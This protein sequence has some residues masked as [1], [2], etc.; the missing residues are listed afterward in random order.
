MTILSRRSTLGLGLLV[1][2]GLP[3]RGQGAGPVRIRGT[4]VRLEG[5][6][7]AV[8]T[9]ADESVIVNLAEN[10]TVSALRRVALADLTPGT[11]VGV[12]AEPGA[13]GELRATAITVLPPGIRIT[14]LQSA[15]DTAPNAS[16]NN[17]A[18]EA[19][20][21]SSAG[22]DLTLSILGRRVLVRVPADTPLLMPIP[23]ARTDLVAGATVFINA[24]RGGDGRISANRV[25]VS[26][27]GVV[28]VI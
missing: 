28:P 27:D 23:A 17:G 10:T 19:A 11:S 14:E 12:V 25:T 3:A 4:I 7:L 20:V 5:A 24:T 13:D 22:R 9:R 21:D 8:T 6:E 18:V 15:W 1:L 16:M 26:K 2:S